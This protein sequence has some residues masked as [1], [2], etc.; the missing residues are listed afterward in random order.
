MHIRGQYLNEMIYQYIIVISGVRAPL[1]RC[2]ALAAL[3]FLA[4]ALV[5]PC[6]CRPAPADRARAGLQSVGFLYGA[7]MEDFGYCVYAWFAGC[8]LA[9]LVRRSGFLSRLRRPSLRPHPPH[10]PACAADLHTGVGLLQPGSGEVARP[11][12]AGG[13]GGEE[14]QGEEAEENEGQEEQ[15]IRRL[16]AWGDGGG[17]ARRPRD[18]GRDAGAWVGAG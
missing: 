8:C 10:L 13:G 3:R 16:V 17:S 18:A 9:G 7:Y 12:N 6:R 11:K 2:S 4:P 14:G 15:M 5:L 1:S